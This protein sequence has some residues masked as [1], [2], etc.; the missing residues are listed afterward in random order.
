MEYNYG[1]YGGVQRCI[2]DVQLRLASIALCPLRNELEG[3]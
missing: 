3:Y 2:V 1:N